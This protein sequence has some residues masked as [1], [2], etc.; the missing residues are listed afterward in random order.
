[1]D[2]GAGNDA[3]FGGHGS[4]TFVGNFSDD[5]MIGEYGR[6]TIEGGRVESVVRLGQ[7][8]LDLIANRQ[9]GLY[10]SLAL[11]ISLAQLGSL[12]LPTQLWEFNEVKRPEP[13]LEKRLTHHGADFS[14]AAKDLG[15]GYHPEGE[16]EELPDQGVQ[17]EQLVE[18][19]PLETEVPEDMA[20][21]EPGGEKG[22]SLDVIPEEG[23]SAGKLESLESQPEETGQLLAAAV[24]GFAGWGLGSS[25]RQKSSSASSLDFTKMQTEQNPGV[26]RMVVCAS[27]AGE[28]TFPKL[29]NAL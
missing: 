19:R 10:S 28:R 23:K 9:F 20:P 4:D 17:D 3:M 11:R 26:G 27:P 16:A 21:G 25:H 22:E 15:Y 13:V 14:I 29:L 18:P 24:A 7:G 1:M 12:R 8:K 2:G 6:L 5:L